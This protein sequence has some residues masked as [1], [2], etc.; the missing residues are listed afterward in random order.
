[1]MLKRCYFFTILIIIFTAIYSFAGGKS[2]RDE[3][4]KISDTRIWKYIVCDGYSIELY[5]IPFHRDEKMLFKV[6]DKEFMTIGHREL[7]PNAK[8]I[9]FTLDTYKSR[10]YRDR[11]SRDAFIIDIDKASI[12]KVHTGAFKNIFL[13][14]FLGN[15]NLLFE[16]SEEENDFIKPGTSVIYVLDL[17]TNKIEKFDNQNIN[18]NFTS[19][20]S[21]GDLLVYAESGGFVVY[22]VSS[23]TSRKININGD[24]PVLSP[25]GR[26]ILFRRG[27][28]TGD[29][30]IISVND[31]NETLVL[32]EEKICSLLQGS[33]SYRDLNFASWS[34]DSKFILFLE[35]SDLQKNRA[36]VLN[37]ETKEVL[38]MAK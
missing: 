13:I 9:V 33:G 34:P 35:S 36:F 27:G 28:M 18:L 14:T 37:A 23:K 5:D 30:H 26:W 2:M 1:M 16:N 19:V 17:K 11:I 15:D 3:L 20:S 12:S 24:R 4:R 21:S 38:E 32:S 8:N 25:D 7:S 29:Y 22:D 6:E 31:L 10:A